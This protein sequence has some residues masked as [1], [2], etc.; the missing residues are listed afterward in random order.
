M[1][2][3]RNPSEPDTTTQKPLVS[4]TGRPLA[5]HWLAV[6]VLIW[7]GQAASMVTSF[8]ASFA[9]VWY[10]TDTTGSPLML[11]AMSICA[12]LPTGL[13][14]PVGGVVA[15]RFNRKAVLIAADMAVGLVSLAMGFVIL[16]GD[17]SPA[18]ILVLVVARSVGQAFHSP[19]MMATMPMLVPQ[20]H[21]LRINTLDQMLMAMVNVGAPA[22]GI[23]I[24]TNLGFQTAMFLDFFGALL[25]C[26]A[27]LPAKIPTT[28]DASKAVLAQEEAGILR[29]VKVGWRALA[30]NRG[31]L[32]FVG[33]LAL[34]QVA[35]GPIAS[36]YP[37]MTAGHFGGDG[38]M[39]S[40]VEATF[41][42]GMI[43]GSGVLMAWGGGRRL[44]LLVALSSTASGVL[45]LAAG[46]LP[47]SAIW[48]F[49]V[50][51]GI[52]GFF[53]AWT[54]G[55]YMTLVQ[56]NVA[57]DKLGRVLGFTTMVMGLATPVGIAIGGVAAEAV[58]VAPFFAVDGAIC[59]VL[60]LLVYM[61]RCVRE[62]DHAAPEASG[63]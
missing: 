9:A 36:L 35:F 4:A 49:V 32:V 38:Y 34:V 62:L 16:A 44:V 59:A 10:M 24:Y 19:A 18:L 27:L 53:L 39:A 29:D 8:S 63:E 58:G 46:L 33:L 41:A 60:G 7:V 30:D 25:A 26:A 42:V 12:Y 13:L 5:A 61:P 51:C 54:N 55:P 3:S 22:L 15:D 45:C 31:L 14:S 37:L 17:L 52:M 21:L 50:L 20:K 48:V 6:V 28:W 56:N 43:V 1:H 23:M 57:E 11:A 47:P 2:D 40:V